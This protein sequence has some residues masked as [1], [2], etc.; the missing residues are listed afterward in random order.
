M[1]ICKPT[2]KNRFDPREGK[3]HLLPQMALGRGY[4][5][6]TFML[7]RLL[8]VSGGMDGEGKE[9]RSCETFD[10]AANRWSIIKSSQSKTACVPRADHASLFVDYD[11]E[12][13]LIA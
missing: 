5:S 6:A 7:S 2:N 13:F 12:E 1:Y 8:M 9:L 11:N 4:C 10:I 3:W